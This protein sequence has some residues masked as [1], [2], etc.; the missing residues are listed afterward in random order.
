MTRNKPS[1]RRAW[2]GHR[3]L[4]VKLAV[5]PAALQ[6]LRR[7]DTLARLPGIAPAGP[8]RRQTLIATYWDTADHALEAAGMALRVRCEDGRPVMTL[9]ADAKQ[10]GLAVDRLEV[11][12][13]L[14]PAASA[15]TPPVPAPPL[16]VSVRPDADT[17][18]RPD[19]PL[20][21]EPLLEADPLREGAPLPEGDSPPEADRGPAPVLDL[22]PDPALRRRLRKLL[23]SRPLVPRWQTR[24]ER[25]SR[26]YAGPRGSRF[27]VALDHGE[28][29][30]GG[31]SA[32][33]SEI[34]FECQAGPPA[35]M[36]DAIRA[37]ALEVPARLTVLGKAERASLLETGRPPPAVRAG[38]MP[39]IR[40]LGP[41]AACAQALSACLHHIIANQP[42]ILEARDPEG[43]HQMRIGI[44]RLR[45]AA[46][47]FRPALGPSAL[48]G[49]LACLRGLFPIL[50]A[51]RDLDVFV[52]ET[53]PRLQAAASAPGA[54]RGLPPL[55]PLA[56]A[57][58]RERVRAWAEVVAR[59]ETRDVTLALIDIA[60]AAAAL[61]GVANA[62]DAARDPAQDPQALKRLARR[63][64]ARRWKRLRAQG[65]HL[66]A[67]DEGARHALR[68]RLK[69]L[70]YEVEVFAPLFGPHKIR[71]FVK[72]LR[73]LQDGLGAMNDAA[74]AARLAQL[75]ARRAGTPDAALA[76]GFT[77]GWT[78]A[79]AASLE[80]DIRK[81]WKRLECALWFRA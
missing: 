39:D 27:E 79:R 20:A 7:A 49:P 23:G 73:R 65:R 26:V 15:P 3:E 33:V 10:A 28:I 29:R 46:G 11:N 24:I 5:P 1:E 72:A 70:R 4:E 22:L 17:A 42:S 31:R 60:R 64:L 18:P 78:L 54:P 37:L 9:K 30:A 35:A 58:G 47:A 6:R 16:Q 77:A 50:G 34:E 52:S 2:Q 36:L 63:R 53:I 32:P 76:A 8:A 19:L 12:V 14:P 13:P 55:A 61:Q 66:Q 75:A 80:R 71:P 59:L 51:A 48:D 40:G 74:V 25:L 68:K 21:A 44:R 81:A 41:A 67:L 62:A 69:K 56:D 45:A 57:A 38:A 43:I